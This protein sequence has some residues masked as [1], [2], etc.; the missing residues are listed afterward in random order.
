M[1]FD[2]GR[3]TLFSLSI[4]FNDRVFGDSSSLSMSLSSSSVPL[5]IGLFI[6]GMGRRGLICSCC[7]SERQPL[8]SWVRA[9]DREASFRRWKALAIDESAKF[10][11]PP[12]LSAVTLRSSVGVGRT[13]SG[14]IDSR[15]DQ[16][17]GYRNNI[18]SLSA[19]LASTR[20]AGTCGLVNG[21]L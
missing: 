3:I 19:C 12:P 17:G 15:V 8:I 20:R 14:F 4:A 1:K 16:G 21:F 5:N 7:L 13:T 10:P 9:S 18:K 6:K 2:I 11:F